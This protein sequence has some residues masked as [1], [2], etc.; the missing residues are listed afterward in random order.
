[1]ADGKSPCEKFFGWKMRLGFEP[2]LKPVEKPK[3]DAPN[4]ART[5]YRIFKP[6]A[7]RGPYRLREKVLVKRP[8]AKILKGQSP[9]YGPLQVVEILGEWT[10]ALSDGQVWSAR[11]MKRYFEPTDRSTS[12]EEPL[13]GVRRSTRLR[14]P[15]N[16]LSY[17]KKGGYG[18]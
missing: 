11:N 12:D 6:T 17:R 10:Y 13:P 8:P 18:D 4:Q 1:M 9:W 5:H 7:N 2:I 16:R 14:R 3:P 15:P